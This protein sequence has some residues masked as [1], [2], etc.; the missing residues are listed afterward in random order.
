MLPSDRVPPDNEEKL[1]LSDEM[2]MPDAGA[3][4]RARLSGFIL[5]VVSAIAALLLLC[6][7]WH[8]LRATWHIAGR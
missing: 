3:H 2:E 5:I 7:A 8:G 1:P 4:P 6:A